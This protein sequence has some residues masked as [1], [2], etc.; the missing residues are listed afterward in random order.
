MDYQQWQAQWRHHLIGMIVDG[1][2]TNDRNMRARV[3]ANLPEHLVDDMLKKM[4]DDA[5]GRVQQVLN[6]D[7]KRRA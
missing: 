5:H 4:Y 6:G 2:C 1:M 3:V 7:A